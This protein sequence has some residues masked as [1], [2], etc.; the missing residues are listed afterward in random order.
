MFVSI[1]Q[2]NYDVGHRF[3]TMY[4][5]KPREVEITGISIF[6]VYA[7]DQPRG[8]IRQSLIYTLETYDPYYENGFLK[9]RNLSRIGDFTEERLKEECFSTKEEC[10]KSLY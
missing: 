8:I 10:I 5:N 6:K 9:Y 3:W 4:A 2:P 1:P 7:K